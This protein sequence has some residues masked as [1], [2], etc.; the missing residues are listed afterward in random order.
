MPRIPRRLVAVGATAALTA[1]GMVGATEA[2]ARAAGTPT[3][4]VADLY[5]SLGPQTGGA[6]S[7]FL[8]I[9]FTNTTTHTCALRGFPGVSVLDIHHHQIGGAAAWAPFP[10][11][12]VFLKPA[13]TAVATI[14][15][16]S[17]AVVPSCRQTSTYVRVFP[18][19]SA[20]RVLIPFHLKVC[21]TFE[22]K[23]VEHA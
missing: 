13:E 9:N 21:G 7:V 23:P 17:Q 12:T 18:P 20:Q 22:V 11:H 16:N 3:C 14:R 8:P 1:I 10:V 19:A 6:G 2:Q 15:T 4:H 5:L